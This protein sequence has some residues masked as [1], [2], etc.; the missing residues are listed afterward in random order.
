MFLDEFWA[1][2]LDPL[3]TE[4]RESGVG[5]Y[6]GGV[7]TGVVAYADDLMVLAP[8]RMAAQKMLAICDSYAEKY[9]V[10]FS[11][12]LNPRKSK[13][14][15]LYFVGHRKSGVPVPAP[16]ILTGKDLPWVDRCD[17]L[18]HSLTTDCKFDQDCRE[19]RAAFID[20]SVKVR[21]MFSLAHP[22]E[23]ISAVEKH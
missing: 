17:H 15:A 16:L 11:T 5:C 3:L 19:K 4:L 13:S 23:I 7:F 22:L 1:V 6:V 18:G 9:N 8:N 2:Y 14:K 12:D 10:K 20:S 21:E